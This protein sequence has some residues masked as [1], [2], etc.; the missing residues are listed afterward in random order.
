[1]FSATDTAWAPW[2]VALSDDKRRA[3]L[4]VISHLLSKIPYKSVAHEKVKLPKRHISEARK[5][6]DFQFKFIP[7]LF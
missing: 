6:A 4:N 7:E 1:M 5:T 2:Y 3:R